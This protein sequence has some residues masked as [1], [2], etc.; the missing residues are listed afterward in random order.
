MIEQ[1]LSSL[2]VFFPYY[3]EEKNM[4][5]QVTEFLAFLPTIAEKFEI[6]LINDGSVDNT[7]KLAE[8]LSRAHPPVK[9]I[10]HAENQGY[11]AAL[12]TGIQNSQFDWVFFTDGDR[13]FFAED[14]LAFVPHA[15]PKQAVIGYR[16]HRAEGLRRR[17]N[18]RLYKL[19]IDILFQLNV[20]DIDGAFKLL[21]GETL[22]QLP[23]SASGAFI[24]SEML[25]LL[26]KK[27]IK[28]KQLP[29]RHRPRLHGKPTGSN[30][31]VIIRALKEAVTFF[32]HDTTQ[33]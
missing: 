6:L 28:F 8:K 31:R 13:Q 19:F 23:L 22:R 1:K 17:F 5:I 15:K 21:P 30:I 20:R 33:A 12:R 3:N 16:K 29:V 2:S 32:F 4:Q 11:G 24:S 9:V 27:R 26:K 7:G 14:L 25:I 18:A 10:H